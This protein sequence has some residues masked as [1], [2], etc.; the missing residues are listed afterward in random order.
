MT[1]QWVGTIATRILLM[2]MLIGREVEYLTQSFPANKCLSATQVGMITK[3]M[4]IST[5]NINND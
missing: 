1:I 4:H 3:F 2:R 5:N